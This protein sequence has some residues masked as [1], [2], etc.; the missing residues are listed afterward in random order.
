M[1][2]VADVLG[3]IQV[4]GAQFPNEQICIDLSSLNK[5]FAQEE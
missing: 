2:I 5:T 1:Q 4:F 3:E